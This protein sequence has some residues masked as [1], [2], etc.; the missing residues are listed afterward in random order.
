M[1]QD[2]SRH[3]FAAGQIA[4]PGRETAP[5]PAPIQAPE[6]LFDRVRSSPPPVDR[7]AERL[8]REEA[9]VQGALWAR[10]REIETILGRRVPVSAMMTGQDSG[11]GVGAL[12]D[13]EYEAQIESLRSQN[14][15]RLAAL[16]SRADMAA[17]L[18]GRRAVTHY[19]T[20]QGEADART[21]ADGSLWLSVP[22]GP[23]G[24][25]SR[26]PGA[27]PVRA[28][29]PDDVSQGDG[30]TASP[31]VRS[32]GERFSST[33]AD[34][35]QTNPLMAAGR[36]AVSRGPAYDEFEDPETGDTLRYASFGAQVVDHERERRDAYQLMAQSDSWDAGDAS[37]LHRL[38][39]GVSTLGGALGGSATDP[40]SLIAPG[41]TA[42]A[43][44]VGAVGINAGLDAVAQGADIAT[45]VED[46]YRPL[47]TALAAGLGG[48]IQGAAEGAGALAR[49]MNPDP[50]G[51]VGA[52]ASEIDAGS[53]AVADAPQ[54]RTAPPAVRAALARID[55]DRLDAQTIGPAD[56][57]TV[58]ATQRALDDLRIPPRPEV[59]R[60]IDEL[61]GGAEARQAEAAPALSYE[62]NRIQRMRDALASGRMLNGLDVD[63][64]TR[65][66]FE[67]EIASFDARNPP[68]PAEQPAA[69]GPLEA[70][71]TGS[72][73]V[74]EEAP[75]GAGQMTFAL[76]P[77]DASIV[78]DGPS[79]ITGLSGWVREDGAWQVRVTDLPEAARGQGLGVEMYGEVADRALA[80]GSRLVSDPRGTSESAAKVWEALGRRGYAV[81]KN[82]EATLAD[83]TWTVP[84]VA[85]VFEV[86][87]GPARDTPTPAAGRGNAGPGGAAGLEAA[88]YQGRQILSGSFDPMQVE[89]DAA[90]FQFKQAGDEGPTDRLSG[91]QAWD[92]TAAGRSIL[93]EDSDGRVIIA[94]GH[95]RRGLARRLIQSGEDTSPRLDGFLLRAR[96]GWTPSDVRVVAAL[97]NLREDPG[98][99]LDAAKVLREAPHLA[100]D[101]SLPITGEFMANARDL[102]RLSDPAFGAVSSGVISERNGAVIGSLSADRPDLH[103]SMVDL[104]RQGDPRSLDEARAL[105]RE[106]RL[107]DFAE[108]NGLQ[109]DLFGGPPAQSALIARARLRAAVLKQLRGDARLFSSLVRNADAIEAGGNALARTENEARLARDMIAYSAIDKLALRVGVVGDTFGDAAGAVTRGDLTLAQGARNIID[110]LRESSRTANLLDAERRVN[111]DPQPPSEVA[112]EALRPFD[113]PGGKGQAEQVRP[114]PEDAEAEARASWDDLPEVT[115]ER[116]ALDVLRACAPAKG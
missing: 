24:P 85:P 79:G 102:A 11:N 99:L 14:P 77:R 108:E 5:P 68:A 3:P 100:N 18:S 42:V 21:L 12:P 9:R 97:K 89:V 27:T 104:I 22:N 81:Q 96:D 83:G 101:R 116:R 109:D 110:E 2:Q 31:R 41:R 62:A 13:S 37:A 39:R 114:K 34:V 53:R 113:E 47:Q 59:E 4:V 93:F 51:V 43:R 71:G 36:W 67:S 90:R 95:Q 16:E 35:S 111:L 48:T 106:A 29:S 10:H 57:A 98:A 28:A 103:L 46:E 7:V 69:A 60:E 45:G 55:S 64:E 80:A 8:A 25:L 72:R 54:S 115:E 78:A 23:S 20:P 63:A 40:T 70:A 61:F 19:R 26:F 6:S 1:L 86:V 76:T 30:S 15:D 58:Q 94:D 52:L 88:E 92:R 49:A 75:D 38:A 91:V 84:N 112:R 82:A 107:A 87:A 56:G 74:F 44:V 105:V 65:T 66:I 32:L 33:A 73:F 50:G 17:R